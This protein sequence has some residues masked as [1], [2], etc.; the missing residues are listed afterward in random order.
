MPRILPILAVLIILSVINDP[1]TPLPTLH[2]APVRQDEQA[3]VRSLVKRYISNFNRRDADG[4]LDLYSPDA[5][6]SVSGLSSRQWVDVE[7]YAPK[8]EEKL[9]RH[10]ESGTYITDFEME[11]LEFQ[12]GTAEVDIS[13]RFKQGVFSVTRS[14]SFELAQKDGGWKIVVDDF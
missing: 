2:S 12:D 4:I 13:L 10:D 8:L 11:R 7:E 9:A 5:R 6:V 3:E 14:G 1:Y